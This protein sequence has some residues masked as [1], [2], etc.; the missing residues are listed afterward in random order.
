ME[1]LASEIS[2]KVNLKSFTLYTRSHGG[3]GY[4]KMRDIKSLEEIVNFSA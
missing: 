4:Y 1:M 3:Y 2:N